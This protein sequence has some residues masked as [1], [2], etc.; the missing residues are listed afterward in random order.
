MT[1]G[2][3]SYGY[4]VHM[5]L[6]LG[7]GTVIL[8]LLIA[9]LCG[10]AVG[11]EREADGHEAGAR[12]HLLL[13][14]GAAV[15]GVL[16]TGGFSGYAGDPDDT[17]V[18]IDV[19]RIA[20]YVP[21]GIGFLGAGA[22]LKT[23]NRVRGLTT[24]ASIWLTAGTGLAAGLGLWSAAIT[25]TAIALVALVSERPLRALAN[26]L[27]TNRRPPLAPDDDDAQA[28]PSS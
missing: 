11:I 6:E 25:G 28:G 3:D 8:R 1:T 22:I 13:A 5:E 19:S 24:A 4:N 17:N 14:V 2:C 9:A 23:Q 20:S 16:S 10:V 12:T 21:A 18:T 7:T 27:G 26:R 15:F